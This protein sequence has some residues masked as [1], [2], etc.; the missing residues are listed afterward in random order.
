M[1]TL[2]RI[3]HISQVVPDLAPM[4]A[5]YQALF[6]FRELRSWENPEGGYL[7]TRFEV[8]G[9]SG[10]CWELLAPTGSGSS[11]QPFLDSPVGP[12]LHHI[13]IEVPDLAQAV[14]E[15]ERQGI[16]PSAQAGNGTG[17]WVEA[18][19][20]PP[21]VGSGLL[22]RLTEG[23]GG[24]AAAAGGAA[25][26]G[27]GL[28]II[29]VDHVCQA[30]RSRDELSGWYQGLLG[31]H[32]IWR[33]PDGKHEDLADLVLEIPGRQM[34]WEIIQPVG[35]GSF[36]ERF[37]NTRGAAAH[38]AT[39]QVA[40]WARAMAACEAQGVPSFDANEGETDGAHWNDTFI[41]PKH[42]GGVLVQ[43]FWEEKPG[44]WVRSDKIPSA[45]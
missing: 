16:R 35:E 6:G 45:S 41:H 10:I 29:S 5:Q 23:A 34:L 31:M 26:P 27:K 32:E 28:G 37:L 8:P 20:V 44:V 3:D 19:L 21:A 11:L 4:A 12:G 24:S 22:F 40:D 39:F 2:S 15:L 30:F 17:R 38:H 13:G 33:T 9:R 7:G 43:L 42:T 1:L 18:P 14:S 36:I 25:S